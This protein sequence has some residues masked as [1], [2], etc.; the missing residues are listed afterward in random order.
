MSKKLLQPQFNSKYEFSQSETLEF[1]YKLSNTFAEVSQYANN[2]TLQNYNLVF[3]GNALLENEQFH[4][5]NL[6][7]ARMNMYRGITVNAIVDYNKKV[8][9][10]RNTIQLVARKAE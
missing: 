2:F 1:N 3:R 5:A 8:K 6:R 10:I 7:Y 4:N 9:T